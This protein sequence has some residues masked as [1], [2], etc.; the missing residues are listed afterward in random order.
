MLFVLFFIFWNV[1]KPREWLARPPPVVIQ[2]VAQSYLFVTPCTAHSTP[3][4][5]VL[6][7][8]LESNSGPL[9]SRWHPTISSSVIP[10]SSCFQ[11]FPASGFFPTS[12]LFPVGGQS[13]GNSTSASVPPINIQGCFPLG[14]TGLISLLSK[15]L[16]R[17]PRVFCSTTVQKHQFF[18]IQPSLWPNS[19]IRMWSFEKPSLWQYGSLSAK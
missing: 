12:W 7:L 16:S 10:F 19:H 14:L 1:A 17:V 9:S 4:F 18:S 13:I 15:G 3:G 6:N 11:F 5:P 8:F 2:S